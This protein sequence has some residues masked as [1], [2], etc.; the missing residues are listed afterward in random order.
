M[1]LSIAEPLPRAKAVGG[2]RWLCFRL[3]AKFRHYQRAE[4]LVGTQSLSRRR[5]RD[6]HVSPCRRVSRV[7]LFTPAGKF[8]AH[9]CGVGI[10]DLLED[11]ECLFGMLD[12]RSAFA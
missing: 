8:R 3:R 11:G 6:R 10:S 2:R 4:S 7:C 9:S 12:G 5:K 1:K